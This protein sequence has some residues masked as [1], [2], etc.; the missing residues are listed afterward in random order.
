MVYE[1]TTVYNCYGLSTNNWY[2]LVQGQS[3]AIVYEQRNCYT[4]VYEQTIDSLW[5]IKQF[6]H[7]DLWII[8]CYSLWEREILLHYGLWTNSCYTVIYEQTIATL[9]SMNKH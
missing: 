5:S 3:I 2:T 4:M 1:Q 6:L 8:N 9:W 7:C